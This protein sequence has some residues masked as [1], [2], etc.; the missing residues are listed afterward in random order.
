MLKK[1][2]EIEEV[3]NANSAKNLGTILNPIPLSFDDERVTN[4]NRYQI[5]AQGVTFRNSGTVL[6]F[7]NDI[8]L[9]PDETIERWCAAGFYFDSNV[10]IRFD[11]TQQGGVKAVDI[12]RNVISGRHRDI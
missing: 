1:L 2:E 3:L 9:R 10:K 4:E 6:A 8:P 11:A 7:V 5:Q 12:F